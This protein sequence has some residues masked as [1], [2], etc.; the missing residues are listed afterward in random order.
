MMDDPELLR[1]YVEDHAEEAFTELVGRHLGLVYSTA[2]RRVGQ[3]AHLAE[4][5]AQKVFIDLARKASLLRGRAT[6]SG[7]LYVSTHVASA[8]VVRSERRRKTRETEA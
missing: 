7:W 6:L 3:D 4:D 5:V 2:L 1:R 8:A